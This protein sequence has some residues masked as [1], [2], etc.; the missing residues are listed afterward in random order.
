MKLKVQKREGPV[1]ACDTEQLA[2]GLKQ[3]GKDR[4]ILAGQLLLC[5][6]EPLKGN[7]GYVAQPP[8]SSARKLSLG[9]NSSKPVQVSIDKEALTTV[10]RARHKPV[11]AIDGLLRYG[12]RLKGGEEFIVLGAFEGLTATQV[13]TL[14]FR[15]GELVELNEYTLCASTSHTFESDLHVLLERLRLANL[16][17]AIHW[18][19][20]LTMPSSQSFTV[21]P[22]SLWAHAPVQN[23]TLSGKPSFVRRH[24]AALLVLLASAACYAAA[25][26]LP[27]TKYVRAWD[28]LSKES[29]TLQGQY[30]FA[31]ERLALLRAR[32]A[33]FE[34]QKTG[35]R[36]LDQFKTVLAALAS[37]PDLRVQYAK[38]NSPLAMAKRPGQ[39]DKK[40]ADF[41]MLIEVPRS[42]GLTALAQSQPLLQSLSGAMGMTLRLSTAEAYKDVEKAA[43]ADGKP[44]RQYKIEGDFN[45][46]S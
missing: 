39:A 21:A 4:L 40:A 2:K 10:V 17:A 33:F 11:F 43:T 22:A 18:C 23:M 24:G 8:R 7:A 31:S 26:Y 32:Q 37:E 12:Q 28:E 16:Q 29:K 41:E 14:H 35:D 15:K 6:L 20:P 13:L 36:R 1:F 42:E 27:Y 30:S 3:V 46:A 25:L 5:S 19:G 44:R 38:L 45:H 34:T 9:K